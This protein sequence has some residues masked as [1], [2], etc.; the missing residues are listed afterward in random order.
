MFVAHPVVMLAMPFTTT[1]PRTNIPNKT[2]VLAHEV[3]VGYESMSN[4]QLLAF[5]GQR[6]TSIE[7]LI[8]MADQNTEPFL[9]FDLF[10]NRII[11]LEAAAVPQATTEICDDNSIPA[12][13]S[14][15]LL[16][17]VPPPR[18]A[19]SETPLDGVGGDP[20]VNGTP[21]PSIAEVVPTTT[22]VQARGVGRRRLPGSGVRGRERWKVAA[23]A[24]VSRVGNVVASR[25]HFQERIGG[26]GGR[27]GLRWR[28]RRANRRRK[29]ADEEIEAFPNRVS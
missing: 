27:R 17:K 18:P 25:G 22:L 26:S 11:V 6:V 29:A 28:R 23:A 12:P 16:E 1:N 19:S 2:Q 10:P 7:Q 3:N 21:K 15:D 20:A 14:A 5:N 8:R 13:R 9:R 24:V 4:M